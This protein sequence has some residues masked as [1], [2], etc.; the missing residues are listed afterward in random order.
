VG[1]RTVWGANGGRA[2]GSGAKWTRLGSRRDPFPFGLSLSKPFPLSLS[3]GKKSPSTGSGRTVWGGERC[4]GR[5]A[6]GRTV[7]GRTVRSRRG[8]RARL[9]LRCRMGGNYGRRVL[10]TGIRGWTTFLCFRVVN[11]KASR[12]LDEEPPRPACLRFSRPVAPAP[13]LARAAPPLGFRSRVGRFL[14]SGVTGPDLGKSG[15]KPRSPSRLEPGRRPSTLN[16]AFPNPSEDIAA[17][18]FG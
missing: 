17:R 18:L 8:A 4:G 6:G 3:E 10:A 7:R 14:P 5:T 2:N 11:S 13:P 9:C 1:G 15:P 16:A 12:L